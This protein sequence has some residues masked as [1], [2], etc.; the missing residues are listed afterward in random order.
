MKGRKIMKKIIVMSTLLCMLILTACNTKD[1][2]EETTVTI[3]ET[4]VATNMNVQVDET[5]Q[6]SEVVNTNVEKMQPI[7]RAVT[8]YLVREKTYDYTDNSKYWEILCS[9]I[10][11][12]EYN[13]V[14]GKLVLEGNFFKVSPEII[15]E[16]AY[17][18]F[19]DKA[20]YKKVAIPA[21][22]NI[23]YAR[24]DE[25]QNVYY[26]AAAELGMFSPKVESITSNND[27]SI[28]VILNEKGVNDNNRIFSITL[29]KNENST[30]DYY[31]YAIKNA[32]VIK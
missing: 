30:N 3:G 31:P 24:Y 6:N 10:N 25:K 18:L 5:I 13:P 7:L 9:A 29:I 21:F 27:K 4:Q 16:L 14:Y 12:Y 15:N 11:E 28:T 8:G 1:S 23:Q 19:P 20:D 22:D 2:K 32:I 26:I 17:V